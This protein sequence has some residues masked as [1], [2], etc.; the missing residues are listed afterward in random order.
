MS[1][2]RFTFKILHE[3]Q[4]RAD[5]G[6]LLRGRKVPIPHRYDNPFFIQEETG[7]KA[8]LMK[9]FKLGAATKPKITLPSRP[10]RARFLPLPAEKVTLRLPS[11]DDNIAIKNELSNTATTTSLLKDG[12]FSDLGLVFGALGHYSK[13]A[14]AINDAEYGYDDDDEAAMTSTDMLDPYNTPTE[15]LGS[16]V[17]ETS[18]AAPVEPMVMHPD[19]NEI[20]PEEEDENAIPVTDSAPV[21][22]P[23]PIKEDPDI[24]IKREPVIPSPAPQPPIPKDED[25]VQDED[26]GE[27][28]LTDTSRTELADATAVVKGII[29]LKQ[30]LRAYL[31]I[32]KAEAGQLRHINTIYEQVAAQVKANKALVNLIPKVIDD[33]WFIRGL[34]TM[35]ESKAKKLERF[36]KRFGD[37]PPDM[38]ETYNEIDDNFIVDS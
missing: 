37:T 1:A 25:E 24:R 18:I 6:K 29:N 19:P 4:K 14:K 5:L 28:L 20:L 3:Q 2:K 33:L 8:P 7:I 11:N 17:P 38:E 27:P 32:D 15:S 13:V 21:P 35:K 9:T 31:Q 10:L 34:L 36:T 26:E 12:S 30:A 22:A 16:Y 23:V